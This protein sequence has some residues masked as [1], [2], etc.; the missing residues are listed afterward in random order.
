MAID[1]FSVG[2]FSVH[3]YG[4]MI[5]LGFVAA[6][7]AG[8]ILAKKKG[9]SDNDFI[10]IAMWV[11]IIGFMGG[12]LLHVIVEFK[13]FLENPMAVLGSEGFVVYG[14]IITGVLSI[15]VYCRVKKLK[16]L[17]YLDLF[18]AVVPLNQSLGRIGCFLAGCCYGKETD[19]C[20]GV[21]FPEGCIAPAGVKL[22]PTQ[23]F[24]AAGDMIFFIALTIY[25]VKTKSVGTD[26]ETRMPKKDKEET[27][28]PV[29]YLEPVK[30]TPSGCTA[31]LYLVLYSVGRFII[32]FFR[33]D[34]RGAVGVLSTSQFIAIFTF[35]AGI[36]LYFFISNKGKQK[37]DDFE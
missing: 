4:L 27:L 5:G 25:F 34:A 7:F 1:L 32:E 12:K 31:S 35:I 9:L 8:C 2:P 15:V 37:R 14:G 11:L 19:S 22:L 20:L 6:I 10:N 24:M 30:A 16:V 21:V 18:G 29:K 26:Y 3:G 23:L 36:G 33:N 28:K 17:D 13:A